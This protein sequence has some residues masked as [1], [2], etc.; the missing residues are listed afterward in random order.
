MRL[1]H[2]EDFIAT[3]VGWP[4]EI[5]RAEVEPLQI[6]ARRTVENDEAL[7]NGFEELAEPEVIR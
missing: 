4:T 6:G 7:A 5:V 3:L 2:T 1:R